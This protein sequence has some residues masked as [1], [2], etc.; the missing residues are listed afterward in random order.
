MRKN[1]APAIGLAIQF[2]QHHLD[3][4]KGDTVLVLP[5]DHLLEPES[6]FLKQVEAMDLYAKKS[7]LITFGIRP[8]KPETGYGYIQVGTL[9]A[10]SVFKS[11]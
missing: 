8:T 11:G 3:A 10:S 7:K 9:H 1:T 4:K 5:S 2:L 6:F